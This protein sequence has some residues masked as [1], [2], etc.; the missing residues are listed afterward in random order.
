MPRKNKA[1]RLIIDACIAFAAGG[2]NAGNETSKCARDFLLEVREQNFIV[3]MNQEL[4]IEWT[5]HESPFARKWR[6]SM[7]RAKKISF[8]D[9][10]K[11][12]QKFWTKIKTQKEHRQ[13]R[14]L[15][16][17]D[18]PIMEAAIDT[19]KRIVSFDDK[20]RNAF[21]RTSLRISELKKI[22]WVDPSKKENAIDWLKNGAKNE[23][24]RLL[25]TLALSL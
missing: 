4:Y 17:K 6:V 12:K 23:K 18:R 2:P 7:V 5:N 3:G 9:H 11:N 19:D 22:S 24:H 25:E 1:K 15:M 10:S 13:L 21:A 16:L 8:L 20:A 14:K